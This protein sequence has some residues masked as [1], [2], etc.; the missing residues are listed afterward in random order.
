LCFQYGLALLFNLV[1][2]ALDNGAGDGADLFDLT[3]V[4]GLRCVF[5]LIIEPVLLNNQ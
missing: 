2:V 1:V 5:A 3:D 4:D